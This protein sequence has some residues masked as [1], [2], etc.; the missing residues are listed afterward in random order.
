MKE[1]A[2]VASLGRGT[3]PTS[4]A[5]LH[6]HRKHLSLPLHSY[7]TGAQYALALCPW[8][9][10]CCKAVR[11]SQSATDASF[12]TNPSLT[13]CSLM[14]K[15]WAAQAKGG[16]DFCHLPEQRKVDP[17]LGLKGRAYWAGREGSLFGSLRP[18]KQ[19]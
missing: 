4:R 10:R 9:S 15:R 18:N 13:K 5:P 7:S 19:K 3:G 2:H 8:V 17:F 14:R 11:F 6:H 1:V 12:H 16:S